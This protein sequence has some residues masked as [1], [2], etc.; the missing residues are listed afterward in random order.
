MGFIWEHKGG[1]ETQRQAGPREAPGE[2]GAPGA[3]GCSLGV[4]DGYRQ[5][6]CVWDVTLWAGSAEGGVWGCLEVA[7]TI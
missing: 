7:S 3:E 6:V 1:I 5:H 4:R 2:A